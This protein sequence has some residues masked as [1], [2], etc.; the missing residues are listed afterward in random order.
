MNRRRDLIAYSRRRNASIV[1]SQLLKGVLFL[2]PT[3]QR[4][5][6]NQGS[7]PDRRPV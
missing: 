5:A 7:K 3:Y 4:Q 2:P 1:A 6:M